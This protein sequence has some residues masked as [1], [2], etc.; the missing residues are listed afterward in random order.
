MSQSSSRSSVQKFWQAATDLQSGMSPQG[1]Y[2]LLRGGLLT[3]SREPEGFLLPTVTLM[4]LVLSLVVGTLVFR[5]FNRTAE[6][7]GQRQQRALYNAATPAIDRAKLKLEYLFGESNLPTPPSDAALLTEL[8]KKALYDLKAQGTTSAE[9]RLDLNQDGKAD[10][11]WR[12]TTDVDGD[13]DTEVVAYS[14]L[15]QS[16][17]GT[18]TVTLASTDATKAAALVV[19]N[20]PI[21]LQ[22]RGS[23]CSNVAASPYAA[24][25]SVSSSDLRKAIQVHAVVLDTNTAGDGVENSVTAT[26]EMQQDRQSDL[27]N[28]W[29]AWF[30]NDLELHPGVSFRWNGAMHTEGSFLMYDN[31]TLF[32]VSSPA[33][34][35]YNRSASELS[36]GNWDPGK[37]GTVDFQG[38]FLIGKI[39]GDNLGSATNNAIVDAYVPAPEQSGSGNNRITINLNEEDAAT[40]NIIEDSVD[41][42]GD[43]TRS[44]HIALNPVVLFTEDINEAR[45][46][47]ANNFD[48]RDNGTNPDW[49]GTPLSKPLD[50]SLGTYNQRLFNA[51]TDIPFLDDTYRADNRIGPAPSYGRASATTACGK[52]FCITAASQ[53]GTGTAD[54][55]LVRLDPLA[56]SPPDETDYGYDGYWERRARRTGVRIIVGQRLELGNAN[57]WTADDSLY[58]PPA[59]AYSG[60]NMANRANEMRQWRTLRDN[61][62]AVQAT[63]IYHYR[64]SSIT[65]YNYDYP[66]AC[67]ATTAHPGTAVTD[68][69]SR[70]FNFTTVA[71]NT[72]ELS[73][74]F[75][76]GMGTNGLEFKAP[77]AD[78]ANP[79]TK[80]ETEINA[81]GSALRVALS[82]LAYFAG[83]PYGAFPATQDS[84]DATNN[85]LHSKAAAQGGGSVASTVGPV[86]H[87]YSPLTM[88][89]NYSELRR[90]IRLL[91]GGTAYTNLSTADKT[92]LHTATC[93]LGMLAYST[94]VKQDNFTQTT[95]T[96]SLNSNATSMMEAT[97]QLLDGTNSANYNNGNISGNG[98]IWSVASPNDTVNTSTGVVTCG[99]NSTTYVAGNT[100]WLNPALPNAD[101]NQWTTAQAKSF[102]AQFTLPQWICA[103]NRVKSGQPFTTSE[104]NTVYADITTKLQTY[105]VQQ[106]FQLNRDRA[107]GFKEGSFTLKQSGVT[108]TINWNPTTGEVCYNNLAGTSTNS[109]S[110]GGGTSDITLTTGCNP[111]SIKGLLTG[112]GQGLDDKSIATALAVCGVEQKLVYPV[113]Y[114][115]LFYIFPLASHAHDGEFSSSS[116]RTAASTA[117]IPETDQSV[118]ATTIRDNIYAKDGYIYAKSSTSG[119]NYYQDSAEG[120]TRFYYRPVEDRLAAT[121]NG[122]VDGTES[123]AS[124]VD[125]FDIAPRDRTNISATP[126]G[127]FTPIT[128]TAT[129]RVNII[130]FDSAG[131]AAT[132]A[133]PTWT[134]WYPAFLDVGIFNSREQMSTRVLSI[135]LDLMRQRRVGL[136]SSATTFC[137]A[138]NPTSAAEKTG[139][140]K[141]QNGLCWLPLPT[142]ME[143]T[144]GVTSTGALIYAFREDAVREDAIARPTR[145]DASNLTC[146]A[147]T[148]LGTADDERWTQAAKDYTGA[149][150][151]SSPANGRADLLETNASGL[152]AADFLMDAVGTNGTNYYDPPVNPCTGV[153]PKP[154]DFYADPDR[155]PHGFALRNGADLRRKTSATAFDK[156][157]RPFTFVTDN[158]AYI[159]GNFN[160]HSTDGTIANSPV[161]EFKGTSVLASDWSNFYSRSDLNNDFADAEDNDN[162]NV[163]DSWRVAEI[164][165]DGVTVLSN[166]F[167][168]TSS[169]NRAGFIAQG[170]LW[171]TPNDF[172]A[173]P[174]NSYGTMH[175]LRTVADPTTTNEDTTEA[176]DSTTYLNNWVL[177]DGTLASDGALPNTL[178]SPIKIS[179][180]GFPVY[181]SGTTDIKFGSSTS[182]NEFLE[183]PTGTQTFNNKFRRIQTTT[184]TTVN[185][186]IASGISPSRIY[187]GYGGMHNFI[188]LIENWQ[189]TQALNFAGSLIQLSFSKYSGPFAINAWEAGTV[190]LDATGLDDYYVAAQ[191]NFG[192]DVALAYAPAGAVA[193][194]LSSP[195]RDRSEFYRELPVTDPYIVNLL[196]ARPDTDGDGTVATGDTTRVDPRRSGQ[197]TCN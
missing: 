77:F 162:D 178:T 167:T 30:R 14:I 71:T 146:D 94:K 56:S 74:D 4:L 76:T 15:T 17:N 144:G 64:A 61:L 52:E 160:L 36:M 164:V 111:G 171:N 90:V 177:E 13:G 148:T 102:L 101:A 84:D 189:T 22:D 45:S 46:G 70:T 100:T 186:L 147:D 72:K 187:H 51:S 39:E 44:A 119:V 166:N 131:T 98:E 136:G 165:A 38:Q 150:A 7:I 78:E 28:R 42:S 197:T 161:Q 158:L 115:A 190:R 194:R 139:S 156:E 132:A 103:V 188:R 83:D 73:T 180:E 96:V 123:M 175:I 121:P 59:N 170:L 47:K 89:G 114:P 88:W 196:C 110:D 192:Y 65:G 63:A 93:T 133:T 6:V 138:N 120:T 149:T 155:R 26:L 124:L 97:S 87:P 125:Y 154:V 85:E 109:C 182:R 86:V 32:L 112:S 27:G 183:S 24:W 152:G 31:P 35:I 82:N 129:D 75:Y 12:Y 104:L 159:W 168:N 134:N 99:A 118:V 8:N 137:T 25:E 68:R 174:A 33:S 135:D 54:A 140:A 20:G 67:L 91:D 57:E 184:P 34:C 81:S 195:S 176:S 193:G 163:I 117:L 106:V 53:M 43:K 11:A 50:D 145:A 1:L 16:Q 130:R 40:L 141:D 9:T 5:T 60:T 116:V 191:R 66:V 157:H 127:W 107:L 151:D 126:S 179:R 21:N 29:G 128:T 19:R 181:R 49:R 185:A 122:V 172:T 62:A 142:L 41:D 55:D 108:D 37:D 173:N 153:S 23:D 58:P 105:I 79:A 2:W 113:R 3:R 69:N 95:Q 169:P 92:T 18:G 80:F 48:A 10:T 143:E